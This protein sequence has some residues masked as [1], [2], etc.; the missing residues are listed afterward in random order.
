MK[1]AHVQ[2]LCWKRVRGQRDA[3]PFQGCA[4]LVSAAKWDHWECSDGQRSRFTAQD[5]VIYHQLFIERV[6]READCEGDRA[7]A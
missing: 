7:L 4:P 2:H 3:A 5:F 1:K 6:P